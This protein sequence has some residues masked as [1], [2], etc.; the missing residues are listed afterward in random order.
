MSIDSYHA[1]GQLLPDYT[2]RVS[3]RAR[4]LRLTVTAAE[5]LVLVV[6]SAW[7]GNPDAVVASKR[8]WAERS[9]ARI[10]PERALYLAGPEALLPSDI[11]LRARGERLQVEYA[12]LNTPGRAGSA[13]AIRCDDAVCVTG[14]ID[15]AA[16]CLGALRRWLAREAASYLPTRCDQLVRE[17]GIAA[18]AKIRVTG[19]KTRWGSCSA[20]GTIMLS[21]SL[22]FL[23]PELVD[24]VIHHEL[25]HLEVL[26]HS[27][28]FWALLAT[29]DPQAMAHRRELKE[30]GGMLPAWLHD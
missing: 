30:A 19:A 26:D 25:A 4:R 29:R 7:H 21:R 8:A 27:P 16:A 14:D 17:M 3:D 15:D 13:K 11:E 5:G 28:R 12:A 2:V 18:P 1:P 20:T 22:M 24:T 9:L 23:L 10:A 6:P